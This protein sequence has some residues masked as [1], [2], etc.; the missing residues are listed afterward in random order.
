VPDDPGAL[1][2]CLTQPADPAGEDEPGGELAAGAAL[3]T[4]VLALHALGVAASFQPADPAGR[5]VLAR[6]LGLAPGREPLGLLVF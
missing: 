3:R 2:C 6:T 4:L 5:P 1:A